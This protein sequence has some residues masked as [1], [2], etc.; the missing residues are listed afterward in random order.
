MASQQS[1]LLFSF[2]IIIQ[3]LLA[4]ANCPPSINCGHLE[5]IQFPFTTTQHPN[6]G[7]L[8]IH[9]CDDPEPQSTKSIQ[10]NN[11]WF[12]ILRI[13]PFTITIRDD[14]LH[15]LLLQK[16]CNILSYNSMFTIQTPLV[17]SR[18]EN[19]VTIFGCSNIDNT[20]DLQQYYSSVSNSTSICI[21][22][23]DPIDESHETIV[24]ATDSTTFNSS[25]L[26]ECSK[27][28]LPTEYEVPRVDTEDLFYFL[29]ADI[30]IKLQVSQDCSTC[31]DLDGGQCRLDTKGHFYCHKGKS[32]KTR[33]IVTTGM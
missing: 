19:Y 30:A 16:S 14:Q 26:K 21:N 2:F 17:S 23:N 25:H 8:T 1:L 29:I 12:D 24:V 13:E 28:E 10:N 22:Q 33:L 6:C 11:K 4:S 3:L 32:N 7:M 20:T 9:G 5:Q 27:V 15:D 18:L 31:H